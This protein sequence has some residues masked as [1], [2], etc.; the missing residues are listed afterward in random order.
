MALG[1]GFKLR[2]AYGIRFR[3]FTVRLWY[4][5]TMWVIFRKAQEFIQ[6][7]GKGSI[8][9]VFQFFGYIVDLIPVIA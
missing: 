9:N 4:R 1:T 3:H 8:V 6:P 5:V 2:K 7:V